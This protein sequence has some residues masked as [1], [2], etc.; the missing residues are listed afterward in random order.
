M[1]NYMKNQRVATESAFA[2]IMGMVPDY[3]EPFD[4]KKSV[5]WMD[6]VS[7][8]LFIFILLTWCFS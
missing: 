4:F 8:F 5:R 6:V 7:I 3:R 2:S 1:E